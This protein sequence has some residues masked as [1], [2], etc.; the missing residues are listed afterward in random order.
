MSENT[1]F[2]ST[3]PGILT[4]VATIITA[5]TGFLIAIDKIDIFNS[6]QQQSMDIQETRPGDTGPKSPP[7]DQLQG[8]K[9]MLIEV[10]KDNERGWNTNDVDLVMSHWQKKHYLV[11]EMLFMQR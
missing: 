7:R 3:L 4:G 8:L 6:D 2:W 11:F 9:Q 5:T 10:L 1:S